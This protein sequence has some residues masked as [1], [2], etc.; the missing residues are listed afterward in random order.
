MN[1][2]NVLIAIPAIGFL[3]TLLIPRAQAQAIRMFTLMISIGAFLSSLGLA[4]GFQSGQP[5]Q[6]FVTDAVWIANPEIH[7]H[8][9]IDGLSL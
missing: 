3:L 4:V 6:Q 1:T 2:L 5:G 7:W 9:G 8:V